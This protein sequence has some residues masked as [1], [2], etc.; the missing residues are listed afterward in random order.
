MTTQAISTG[1]GSVNNISNSYQQR[2]TDEDPLGMDAF[3]TM[4]VAQLQNQDPMNPMEGTEFSSQLAQFSQLEQA[5][6]TN[7]NLEALIEKMGENSESNLQ[8]YIGKEVVAAVDSIE[9]DGGEAIGGYYTVDAPSDVRVTIYNSKGEAVR[10]IYPGQVQP[11]SHAIDWDGKTDDGIVSTDGTYRFE[12]LAHD[13][14]GGYKAVQTTVSGKVDGILNK[15]GTNYL[16][17]EGAFVKPDSVLRVWESQE[18][19]APESPVSYIG[20]DVEATT[21]VIGLTNGETGAIPYSLERDEEVKIRIYDA[22]GAA[23][24]EISLGVQEK[25]D[26]TFTWDGKDSEEITAPNGVYSYQVLTKGAYADTRVTG[27]VDGVVYVGG[28]PYLQV[29]D[30]LVNPAAIVKVAKHI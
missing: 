12:V 17:V 26:N 22:A 29:G 21:G 13:G 1:T 15:D 27:E 8:D 4:L 14:T 28:T 24:K 6:N 20:R 16:Q 19:T 7:T 25:G 23:V 5:M 10:N 9:V 18:E 11:G 30:S 2:E 3:L